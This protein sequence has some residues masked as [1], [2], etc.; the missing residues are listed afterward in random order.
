MQLNILRDQA[1]LISHEALSIKYC[2]SVSVALVIRRAK[3]M[4]SITYIVNCGL[5]GSTIYCHI[6]SQTA[7]F[8]KKKKIED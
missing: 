1:E 2:G 6:I 5:S 3:R 8:S 7:R 4:L